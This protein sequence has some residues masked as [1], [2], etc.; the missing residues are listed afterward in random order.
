MT[1][2]YGIV[3]A[4]ILVPIILGALLMTAEEVWGWIDR[5]QRWRA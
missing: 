1:W 2:I 4:V 3:G 5:R